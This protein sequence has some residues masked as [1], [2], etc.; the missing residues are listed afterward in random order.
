MGFWRLTLLWNYDPD[1]LWGSADQLYSRQPRSPFAAAR[2][3]PKYNHKISHCLVRNASS[4]AFW[5]S[6]DTPLHCWVNQFQR[7]F[8]PIDSKGSL[9]K[10]GQQR[11]EYGQPGVLN[12]LQPVFSAANMLVSKTKFNSCSW[13]Y[14][15]RS[16]EEKCSQELFPSLF[17][18]F[19]FFWQNT[20]RYLN[21]WCTGLQLI[22]CH[23][24]TTKREAEKWLIDH[25]LEKEGCLFEQRFILFSV[26]LQEA[27]LFHCHVNPKLTLSSKGLLCT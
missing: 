18:S 14:K 21:V 4:T 17:F 20:H 13:L 15:D 16:V 24:M 6:L 1:L 9:R 2:A 22:C 10:L 25:T 12:F 23:L 5:L 11:D 27:D 26:T 19:L 8:L 7:D 3:T